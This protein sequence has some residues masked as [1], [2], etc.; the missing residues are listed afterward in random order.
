MLC[1]LLR[2]QLHA[3]G[4][5][6]SIPDLLDELAR[7]REVAVVYPPKGRRRR[8]TIQ[9]TLSKMSA[10]QRILYEALDLHRYQHGSM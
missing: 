3:K 10:D 2:R 7:I 9:A 1:S 8:L 6:R 5:H 4:I